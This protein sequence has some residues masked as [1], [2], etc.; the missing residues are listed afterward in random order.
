MSQELENQIK[1]ELIR[2]NIFKKIYVY[3]KYLIFFIIAIILIPSFYSSYL[4]Y[5]KSKNEEFFQQYS[6]AIVLLNKNKKQEAKSIFKS[7]L[8]VNNEIIIMSSVNQLLKNNLIDNKSLEYNILINDIIQNKK[9]SNSYLD[10]LKIKKSLLIFDKSENKVLRD[11]LESI[12]KKSPFFE[13]SEQ[14]LNDH[15]KSLN[16][17]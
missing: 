14:I 15:S 5:N 4:F 1:D 8:N 13:I 9:I 7:L 12:D 11:L 17:K 10:I 6:Q 2:E 3:K 16:K